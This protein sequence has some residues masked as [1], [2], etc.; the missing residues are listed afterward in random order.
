MLSVSRTA[1]IKTRRQPSARP[2][3]GEVAVIKV[4]PRVMR[5]ALRL[6]KGDAS[7]LRI[8]GL[9]RVEILP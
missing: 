4:D 2:R 8:L 7:K 1:M 3:S 9:R 5:E 6:V